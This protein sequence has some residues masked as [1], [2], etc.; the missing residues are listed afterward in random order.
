MPGAKN[1]KLLLGLSHKRK[2]AA[3][4]RANG[5]ISRDNK[6]RVVAKR[7]WR[8]QWPPA[9]GVSMTLRGHWCL[10]PA[11]TDEN[12]HFAKKGQFQVCLSPP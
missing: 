8:R 12:C 5:F 7:Q 3:K 1:D 10:G 4:Q 9:L 11:K 2:T 6:G